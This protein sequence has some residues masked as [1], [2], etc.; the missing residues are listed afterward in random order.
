MPSHLLI[1]GNFAQHLVASSER[2]RDELGYAEPV[3]IDD[4]IRRTLAWQASHASEIKISWQQFDYE[5]ED[6]ALPRVS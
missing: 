4:A 5:A 3:S 6:R 2:I 1:P